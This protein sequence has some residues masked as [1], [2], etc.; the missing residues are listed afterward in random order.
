[1]VGG[2]ALSLGVVARGSHF[3]AAFDEN[4]ALGIKSVKGTI[5]S[6]RVRLT[7]LERILSREALVAVV[8]GEGLDSKMD[9]LVSLQI[10]VAVEALRALVTL[11]RSVVGG[12]LLVRRM[13][14]KVR[15]GC[16]VP[17]VEAR[18]HARVD[19]DQRQPTVGVLN[20]GEDGCW[21]GSVG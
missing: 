15:H 14:H 12:R 5:Q 8:A 1:M 21:T 13:S 11:E 20:V 3:A 7:Y 6:A 10:V 17:T 19:T 18:H 16:R 2:V 9:P 4:V